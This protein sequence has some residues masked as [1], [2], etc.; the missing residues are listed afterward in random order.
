MTYRHLPTLQAL[1]A[2]TNR[3]DEWKACEEPPKT[4]AQLLL[5]R[6]GETYA[7]RMEP[8]RQEVSSAVQVLTRY[9]ATVRRTHTLSK[10]ERREIIQAATVVLNA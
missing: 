3:L 4:M 10:E 2:L 9:D 6:L 5:R 1:K 8:S 7:V